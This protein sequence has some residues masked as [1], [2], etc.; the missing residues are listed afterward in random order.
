[1]NKKTEYSIKK[2]SL[3]EED[4]QT[5]LKNIKTGDEKCHGFDINVPY[6]RKP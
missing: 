3:S 4:R 2:Y 1:M 6:S 5:Y